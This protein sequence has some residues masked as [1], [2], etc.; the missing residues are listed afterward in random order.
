MEQMVNYI[1]I[2]DL[3]LWTENPRD[4]IDE[5]ATD[6][7]IADKAFE[8]S[9]SKWSL[10]KLSNQMGKYYDLSEIPT[11]V[12][13]EEKPVVYDGNRRIILGKIKHG[14]VK[15][16]S[17]L[18]LQVPDI[19]REI[20]CNVC[21]KNIALNNVW[22]KHGNSGSW[23]QLEQDIFLHKFLNKEKSPFLVL[24]ESTR[25]V[26]INPHLNK[27]FVQREIFN[28]SNLNKLG[29]DVIEGKLYSTHTNDEIIEI[30]ADI[31][32]KIGTEITTRKNRGKVFEVLEP[33]S[34]EII[35]HNKNNR[36]QVATIKY[37]NNIAEQKREKVSRRIGEKKIELFGGK[38]YLR[39]GQLSNL[40]R[41]IVDLYDFYNSRKKEL[42]KTFP[43]LIRMS[44]RLL[45]EIAA[46]ESDLDLSSYLKSHFASAKNEVDK[47]VKTTFANQNI[48]ENSIVQLLHTG[49]HTYQSSNNLE[50][51]IALS[52]IIGSILTL[53]HGKREL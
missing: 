19:P 16:P 53:S 3:V 12:Y 42:S 47:D 24:E 52:V 22:R 49:A 50:Q 48:T 25:I 21:K 40:Y 39:P 36:F 13:H 14:F 38:L 34:K 9:Q 2:G 4:I 17:S 1:D 30:L 7:E 31:S 6:Q 35:E 26:S 33:S 27:D 43:G 37:D 5:N 51:T 28:K 32:K 10:K 29:F 15:V 20:P 45:C 23:G 44:L 46:K 11:V 18:D 8:D 41:D